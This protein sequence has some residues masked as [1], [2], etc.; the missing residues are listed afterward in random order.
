MLTERIRRRSLLQPLFFAL[1][2]LFAAGCSE[3]SIV[4]PGP[5][6]TGDT[7]TTSAP[8]ADQDD[9]E[10]GGEDDGDVETAE[11]EPT[12][13]DDPTDDSSVDDSASGEQSSGDPD[14]LATPNVTATTVVIDESSENAAAFTELAASGLVLSLDEQSC[15]DT[16]AAE[17]E[18]QGADPI[19]AVVSAVQSCA[20]AQAVDDF[21][22]G[23]IEAGGGPLPATEAACVSS[24]LQA[25][26]EYRPFWRALL[27]E[28]PFDFLLAE[29]EVQNRYLDLFSE[30]V[31]VGRAVSQQAGVSLSAPT[32]GC[33]DDLYND[34]E[35]VRVTILADLSG[36]LDE[37]ARI[38]SQI[39][40][41]FTSQELAALE[42]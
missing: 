18:T 29:T 39:A 9:D 6:D 34:R 28:E 27:D 2:L 4:E 12:T 3:A 5:A 13:T 19:D 26:E 22:A 40:G 36:D 14:E 37:R 24:E 23:L 17:A 35:F 31:S 7:T 16:A 38:D 8:D 30:C 1:F 20:S 33:I 25:T 32:Q 41:C 11:D 15:T 42:G 21:A 10:D